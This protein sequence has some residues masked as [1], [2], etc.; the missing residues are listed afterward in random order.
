MGKKEIIIILALSQQPSFPDMDDGGCHLLN[1]ATL[2][3]LMFV[4]VKEK[5]CNFLLAFL[6]S[7]VVSP[8]FQHCKHELVPFMEFIQ[9]RD[10]TASVLQMCKE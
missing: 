7:P 5:A 10:A 6:E 3:V 2:Q 1:F 4:A 9:T 8:V